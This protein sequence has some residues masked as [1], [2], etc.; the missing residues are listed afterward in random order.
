MGAILATRDMASQSRRAAALDGGHHLQLAQTDVSGVGSAPGSTVR[1]E[2]IRDLQRW[3]GHRRPA[4]RGRL[5]LLQRAQLIEWAHDR[6]DRVGGNA[7]V[8][9]R[10]IQFGVA[11][12][13]LDHADVDVLL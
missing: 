7:G 3:T 6:A 5:R 1:A 12:E 10:R 4:L 9:R 2:N 11:H 13:N 8:E